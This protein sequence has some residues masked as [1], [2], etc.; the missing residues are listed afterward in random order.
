MFV[1]T[2]LPLLAFALLTAGNAGFVAAEFSLVTVDRAAVDQ[3]AAAGDA[4]ARTVRKALRQLSFQLSGAQLG[5]TITA[6]LTGYLAEPALAKLFTPVVEPIA[7]G[8][9]TGVTHVLAAW[10]NSRHMRTFSGAER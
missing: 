1:E 2:I 8:A 7:K 6:L 3:Q 10:R 5:I 4:K 9:T